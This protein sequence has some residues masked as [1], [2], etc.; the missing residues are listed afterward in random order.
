MHVVPI[1][2]EVTETRIFRRND[3][4]C[5]HPHGFLDAA[6]KR[7][8]LRG[9]GGGLGKILIDDLRLECAPVIA[10]SLLQL[11]DWVVKCDDVGLRGQI[12]Y[13]PS[14]GQHLFSAPRPQ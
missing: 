13:A 14:V 4:A 5:V 2:G 9:G 6:F 7:C 3:V 11:C 8:S 12:Q 1:V 10:K